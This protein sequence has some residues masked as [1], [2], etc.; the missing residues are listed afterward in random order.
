M[1]IFNEVTILLLL[2]QVYCFSPL[3]KLEHHETS[4]YFFM[5]TII[6]NMSV[7]LYFIFASVARDVY[8]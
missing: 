1:E 5:F 7:H 2:S 6:G 4:G 3:T 8:R